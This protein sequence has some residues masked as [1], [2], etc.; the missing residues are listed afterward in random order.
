[1]SGKLNAIDIIELPIVKLADMGGAY[2][3]YNFYENIPSGNTLYYPFRNPEKMKM[4][5]THLIL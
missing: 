3:P 2:N 4:F 1:M 5:L